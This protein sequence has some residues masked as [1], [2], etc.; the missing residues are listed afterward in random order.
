[1]KNIDKYKLIVTL[2]S[3]FIV[4]FWLKKTTFWLKKSNSIKI[5]LSIFLK[6]EVKF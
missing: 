5:T 2:K 3:S 4:K 1:M 6:P